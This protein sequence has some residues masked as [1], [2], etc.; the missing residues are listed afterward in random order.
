MK[1]LVFIELSDG[2]PSQDSLGL[3]QAL[4]ARGAETSA[5]LSAA[6]VSDAAAAAV[7]AYCPGAVFAVQSPAFQ[8]PVAAPHAAL[9]ADLVRQGGYELLAFAASLLTTELSAMLAARLETGLIW[10]L[11]DLRF[12]DGTVRGDRATHGDAMRAVSEWKTQIKI[13]LFRPRCFSPD[14]APQAGGR[15]ERVT[16]AEPGEIRVEIAQIDADASTA[17]FLA[18]ADVIVAGGRGIGKP[19]NMHVIA[20]LAEA[21][22]GQLGVS[23]PLVD[24]G[25]APRAQQ[26]GQT[27]TVVAP[28]LYVACGISGQIQH[29]LG[30]ERS[31][32]VIAVNKDRDAP[33]MG[34][35]DLGIVSDVMDFVP[36]LTEALRGSA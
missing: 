27:G 21:L 13:A 14:A 5:V 11:T 34:F 15:I 36:R 2:M 6:Q 17:K 7:A 4:Q 12:E 29:K 23:L 22:H 19:E 8:T 26:V 31:G 20:A 10:N 32:V 25:W 16:V 9:I 3:L 18:S 28:R 24:M 30:M 33:I 35:C 1:T